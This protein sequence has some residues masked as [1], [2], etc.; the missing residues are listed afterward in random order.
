MVVEGGDEALNGI[1]QGDNHFHPGDECKWHP[2]NVDFV[3]RHV[4]ILQIA[5]HTCTRRFTDVHEGDV[6]KCRPERLWYEST[7]DAS[8]SIV[9]PDQ[10]VWWTLQRS[11]PR[12]QRRH[13]EVSHKRQV[14]GVS[15]LA[16]P[17]KPAN[18]QRRCLS[19]MRGE[20]RKERRGARRRLRRGEVAPPRAQPQGRGGGSADHGCARGW[21]RG[22]R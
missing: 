4:V 21:G 12:K 3:K 22:Q 11:V 5:S 17:E 19:K 20:T 8:R 18:A 1:P 16:E 10:T 2:L 15:K 7:L 9:I 13:E 6:S 14:G